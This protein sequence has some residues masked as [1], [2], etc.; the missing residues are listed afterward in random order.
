VSKTATDQFVDFEEA[1]DAV[2]NMW[3]DLFSS[4]VAP[5]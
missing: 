2:M 4:D 3:D 1:A 5:R